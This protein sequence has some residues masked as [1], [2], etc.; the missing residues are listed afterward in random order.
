MLVAKHTYF[1]ALDSKK[2]ENYV[3]YAGSKTCLNTMQ[4]GGRFE[5][6]VNYAGSKTLTFLSFVSCLFENYVN[7]AGSKTTSFNIP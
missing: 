2:F 6:Y 1:N 5:N 7:Y 4:G 3:N